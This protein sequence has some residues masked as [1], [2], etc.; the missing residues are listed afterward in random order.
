[1]VAMNEEDF[2]ELYV[3]VNKLTTLVYPQWSEGTTI[4]TSEGTFVQPFSQVPTASPLCRLRVG[5]LFTTNYSKANMAR[6][7]GIGKKDFAYGDTEYTRDDTLPELNVPSGRRI[8]ARFLRKMVLKDVERTVKKDVL[9]AFDED[10]TQFETQY[11]PAEAIARV[12]IPNQFAGLG[13]SLLESLGNMD[14]DK[15]KRITV[16]FEA[17][18]PLS[19][20]TPS[21]SALSELFSNENP[22][23]KSFESTMGRGIAVA[24]TGIT[25]DWKL[26][27]VPWELT[28]GNRAP[29]MCEVQLT[30]V[31]IHDITPG[32]DH[33]GFNRAPI[34]RVGE[35]M[36]S[37]GQ[38]AWYDGPG[39]AKLVS[40]IER[41][42]EA[43]LEGRLE[44]DN[45]TL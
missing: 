37:V 16:E 40:D 13:L 43:A 39:H 32:I 8:K 23:F 29:R 31:P 3:K 28:P 25:F 30:V 35:A 7:M 33:E 27:S 4:S 21:T 17:P 6:M 42:H 45:E 12:A 14:E 38:D 9:D 26:G 41:Q 36:R 5:D 34:Y 20:T 11:D 44:G 1:M 18:P 15:Y 19:M 2:E 10:P 24:V 22:I